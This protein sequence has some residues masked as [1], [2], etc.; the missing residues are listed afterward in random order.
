VRD[1]KDRLLSAFAREPGGGAIEFFVADR[2]RYTLRKINIDEN[3][4][5]RSEG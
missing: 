4:I 3:N 1:L 2:R 5:I